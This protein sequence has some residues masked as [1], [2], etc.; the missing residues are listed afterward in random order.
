MSFEE[1]FMFRS[2]FNLRSYPSTRWHLLA[3][4]VVSLVTRFGAAE[5]VNFNL[6]SGDF[7]DPSSVSVLI[8][9]GLLGD[10]E[11]ISSVSGTLTVDLLPTAINPTSA[12]V[13]E[14]DVLVDEEVDVSVGGGFLL[15]RVTVNADAGQIRVRMAE[16]GEAGEIQRG[17]F[18]QLGNLVRF[19]GIARTSV[20]AEPIDLSTFDPTNID[21]EDIAIDS[22]RMSATLDTGFFTELSIPVDAGLLRTT[23]DLVVDGNLEAEGDIPPANYVWQGPNATGTRGNFEV[24]EN[25]LRGDVSGTGSIPLAI[26]T[27]TLRDTIDLNEATQSVSAVQVADDANVAAGTLKTT[28]VEV[29]SGKHLTVVNDAIFQ[30]NGEVLT[31]HG[32]GRLI[33]EGKVESPISLQEATLASA[34]G[35]LSNVEVAS[36]GTLEFSTDAILSADEINFLPG[37]RFHIVGEAVEPGTYALTDALDAF[38][39]NGLYQ[40][41]AGAPIQPNIQ[42]NDS[43]LTVSHSTGTQ[44]V[45]TNTFTGY[46]GDGLLGSLELSADTGF[47]LILEAVAPGDADGDGQVSF[48]DF[49]VL[50]TNFGEAGG[51]AQGD[52][53]GSG[54]VDFADFLILSN[55]FGEATAATSVPEPNCQTAWAILIVLATFAGRKK[56]S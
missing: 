33:V 52:F 11:V 29:P 44:H 21:F 16:S 15:P 49:L 25:W 9:A 22:D 10:D 34:G 18:D 41:A 46:V 40:D 35:E 6:R 48:A 54:T 2:R 50:S 1:P 5:L 20:L 47:A 31:V 43:Q 56:L 42:F 38:S 45:D 55:R 8:D 19:E 4:V 26:D 12:Q 37:G 39:L 36:G 13:V 32:G 51:W 17:R 53:D 28:S 23:I 27:V 14:L 30:S 24:A 3:A 7:P